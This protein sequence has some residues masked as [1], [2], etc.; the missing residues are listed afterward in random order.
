[1]AE[2]DSMYEDAVGWGGRGLM[3][4]AF[5]HMDGMDFDGSL[6]GGGGG[7]SESSYIDEKV[8]CRGG[9]LETS[10]ISDVEGLWFFRCTYKSSAARPR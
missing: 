4:S 9:V 6:R 8:A 1:M 10:W 3:T 7:I 5:I 2:V